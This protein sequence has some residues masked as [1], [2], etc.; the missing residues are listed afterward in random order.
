MM[1]E[2]SEFAEQIG[3][4]Y[5]IMLFENGVIFERKEYRLNLVAGDEIPPEITYRSPD[6]G[7]EIRAYS[8]PIDKAI[9]K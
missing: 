8:W 1:F 7:F 3:A 4:F 6:G 5:V 9:S 2:K